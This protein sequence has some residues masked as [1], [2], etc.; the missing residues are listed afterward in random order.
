MTDLMRTEYRELTEDEKRVV[1]ELK[2]WGNAFSRKLDALL[3]SGPNGLDQST[4]LPIDNRCIA[5]ARTN[6]EQ[7]IMWAVKAVTG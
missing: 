1:R 4:G 2:D 5:L 3:S 7:A 6:A